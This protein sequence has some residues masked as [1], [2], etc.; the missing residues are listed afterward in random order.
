MN[1][2]IQAGIYYYC[3]IRKISEYFLPSLT[4]KIHLGLEMLIRASKAAVANNTVDSNT[5][6][7]TVTI[8]YLNSHP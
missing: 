4:D 8:C 2:S 3:L 6:R 1:V 7:S 5:S